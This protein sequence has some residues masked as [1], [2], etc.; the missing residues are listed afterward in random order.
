MA[1]R[2]VQMST[3]AAAE[4]PAPRRRLTVEGRRQELITAALQLFSDRPADEV[5]LDDV[6]ARAGV[7]RAL[8][9]RYFGTRA[10]IYV[11]AMRSAAD[12]MLALLD[13]PRDAPPLTRL[14][15][16]IRLFFEFAEAHATGF[17]ALLSGHP[18][19][20]SGTVGAIVEEV[21]AA[22][23]DRLVEGMGR[24]KVSAELRLA[25]RSWIASA[26]A[27]ALDWLT[28]RDVPRRAV[29]DFV[30]SQ[31]YAALTVAA[32]HDQEVARFLEGLQ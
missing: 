23:F 14:V 18:G 29:E 12:E 24:Q 27:A 3:S 4:Q 7:S 28:H 10:D 30:L 21:R 9:Y 31:L 26:E 5:T 17:Q 20:H 16:A 11:A 19:A 15:E 32:T 25:L 22:L 6:A 13:P 8:A 1:Y 2:D